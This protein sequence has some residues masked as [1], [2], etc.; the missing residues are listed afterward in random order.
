[1]RAAG[2]RI[3]VYPGTGKLKAQFKYADGVKARYALVLG[4]DEA[5]AGEVNAKELATGAEQKVALADLPALLKSK[6]A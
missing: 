3:D 2:L 6:P 1:M 5:A 4:P